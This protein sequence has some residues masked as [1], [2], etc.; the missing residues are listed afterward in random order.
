MLRKNSVLTPIIIILVGVVL[1]LSSMGIIGKVIPASMVGKLWP[2][3]AAAAALDLLI[4]QNRLIGGLV[5]GF[6]AAALFAMQF[7]P[8]GSGHNIWTLFEKYW[9]IFLVLFGIDCLFSGEKLLNAIVSI[10]L[11]LVVIYAVLQALNVPFLKELGNG[12]N[13]NIPSLIPTMSIEDL[14]RLPENSQP[15]SG[16]EILPSDSYQSF[17]APQSNQDPEITVSGSNVSIETPSQSEVRLNL[18]AAGGKLALKAGSGGSRLLS[19]TISLDGSEKLTKEATAAGNTA[20]YTLRSSASGAV[21]NKSE[22]DLN[23][24]PGKPTALNMVMN[25]G[26]LK[27]DLRSLNLTSASLENKYGPVDVMVP[28]SGNAVIKISVYDGNLRV[29]VPSGAS[30][31][32]IL[33]GEA[34]LDYPMAKYDF[35]GSRVTPKSPAANPVTVEIYVRSGSIQIIDNG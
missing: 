33:S 28:Q 16:V 29:Y 31:S 27:A 24:T 26:Y 13:I 10:L 25:N 14:P 3:L 21:S 2:I 17:P 12:L 4:S 1:Q 19:G 35:D 23:L 8:T 20:I 15:S 7:M 22:W 34:Q 5:M 9:P 32:C 18:N 6:F 30:V 11:A